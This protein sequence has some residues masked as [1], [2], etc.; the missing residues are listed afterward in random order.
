MSLHRG[1]LSIGIVSGL[2]VEI[3]NKIAPLIIL[4]H[5]QKHL[6]LHAFGGAQFGLAW[7]ETLQPLV[8]F[9]YSSYAIASLSRDSRVHETLPRLY[10]N[11]TLLRLG[12]ACLV[13][14]VMLVVSGTPPLGLLIMVLAS[15]AIDANWI[16]LARQKATHLSLLNGLLRVGSMLAIVG[17]VQTPSDQ[18][19]FMFLQ[20]L[21]NLLMGWVTALLVRKDIPWQLPKLQDLMRLFR[22]AL[23]FA[24]I[25]LI[26]ALFDRF[27]LFLMQSWFGLEAAGAYA[28]PA[29]VVL[30]LGALGATVVAAFSAEIIHVK[31]KESLARHAAFSL[32]CMLAIASPIVFGA[33]FVEDE[34]L[35]RLFTHETPQT[36]GVFSW[37]CFS[38]IAQ[39]CITVFGLQ[40]LQLKDRPLKL[41]LG[42]IAGLI[43]GPI[44]AS[45]MHDSLGWLAMP[46]AVLFGKTIAALAL[47]IMARPLI[48]ALPW[49]TFV[50]TLAPGACMALVLYGTV[51]PGLW[52]QLGIGGLVYF[53]SLALFNRQKV[54]WVLRHPKIVRFWRGVL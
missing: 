40:I 11:M 42:L 22:G 8:A 44:F 49:L 32:W 46:G 26:L 28:G 6:G 20:L 30:S 38:I 9:G 54:L 3:L 18:N 37:L 16:A 17:L 48:G 24:L 31:D 29:R 1:R 27:D 39:S 36:H 12:Q 4:H 34:M 45:F 2:I 50:T 15:A 43:S 21:P 13:L 5:A 35:A 41:I 19:L 51:L 33:P 47:M 25:A 7:L 10:Q 52:F 14:G 23:P 53:T